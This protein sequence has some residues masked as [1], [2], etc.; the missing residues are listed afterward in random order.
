MYIPDDVCFPVVVEFLFPPHF[1]LIC[2]YSSV[3]VGVYCR[4]VMINTNQYV[5]C[6]T[7]CYCQLATINT[8]SNIYIAVNITVQHMLFTS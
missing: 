7:V 1:L 3:N 8:P 2:T 6:S 4:P 5:K